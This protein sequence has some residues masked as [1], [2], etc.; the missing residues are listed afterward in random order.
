MKRKY[1]LL[2]AF[3]LGL[4]AVAQDWKWLN[5]CPAGY[6]LS[7]VCFT[8]RD[9]GYAVGEEGTILKTTDGCATLTS[10]LSGTSHFLHAVAFTD[11]GHGC[12]VGDQ[13]EF[14]HYFPPTFLIICI[15]DIDTYCLKSLIIKF[16]TS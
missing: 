15:F 14:F 11:P 8:G 16:L 2:I 1:M 4:I 10:Q 7:S 5:P 9:T 6:H 13:G 3:S 12:V